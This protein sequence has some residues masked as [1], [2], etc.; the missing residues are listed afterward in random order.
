MSDE[1]PPNETTPVK[2]KTGTRRII[3]IAIVALFACGIC[4]LLSTLITNN[5]ATPAAPRSEEIESPT[6]EIESS[7]EALAAG[8]TAGPTE[9]PEPT[10][11]PAPTD[12][13]QP[14]ATPAPTIDATI[15]IVGSNI[16]P[17]DIPQGDPGLGVVLTGPPSMFGVVPVVIRNNTDAPVYDLEISASARDA[18][19]S[20]LGTASGIDIVP[21]YIPPGG[22]AIGSVL[23]SDTPL[24]GASVD[25]RVTGHDSPGFI[26][27]TGDL[28]I[29]ESNLVGRSI[30]GLAMNNQPKALDL[31]KLVV[32]CFDD[33][34][35]PT[36]IQSG[37][38][39]QRR[40][41]SGAELPFSVDLLGNEALCGRYLIAGGGWQTD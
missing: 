32:M 33:D 8:Q 29:I 12:T 18:A 10:E 5:N 1:H 35:L 6:E 3:L 20:I 38:T 31:T 28:E 11:T 30:V 40:V 25:Y 14:T 19:G 27:V 41:E 13:P 22:L 21:S 15:Y 24:D 34:G 4:G 7:P 17:G 16:T 23:F 37:Y 9:M 36:T 39:D 2:K 26:I